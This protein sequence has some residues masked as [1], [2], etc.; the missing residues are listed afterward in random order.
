MGCRER[1]VG[2]IPGHMVTYENVGEPDG[3]YET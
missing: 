3:S 1:I 2:N